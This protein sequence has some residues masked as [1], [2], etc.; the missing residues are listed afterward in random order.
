VYAR[1][2]VMQAAL[3]SRSLATESSYG[4]KFGQHFSAES[5]FGFEIP[6]HMACKF[7]ASILLYFLSPFVGRVSCTWLCVRC[8]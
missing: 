3:D 7:V 1:C 5:N 8:A 2:K 6:R 4:A